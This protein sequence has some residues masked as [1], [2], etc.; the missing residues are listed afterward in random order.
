MNRIFLLRLKKWISE[1]DTQPFYITTEWRKARL[2]A[3]ELW[4]FECYRCRYIKQPSEL[5]EATMVHHVK[6]VKDYPELALSLFITENGR[7]VIQLMPLCFNCHA[8]M[9]SK[10]VRA[11]EQYPEKW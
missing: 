10:A 8:A 6:P 9:E 3:M 11:N 1:G 5:S 7:S 4:H 2:K